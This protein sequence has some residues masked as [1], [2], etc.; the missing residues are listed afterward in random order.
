[1]LL[2]MSSTTIEEVDFGLAPTKNVNN[3]IIPKCTKLKI[4]SL[5]SEIDYRNDVGD[6][7]TR[8]GKKII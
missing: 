2:F 8:K 4:F 6:Q 7:G 3:I 1:M 5:K